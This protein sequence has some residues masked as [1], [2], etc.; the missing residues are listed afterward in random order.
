LAPNENRLDA[1]IAE[2]DQARQLAEDIR[3]RTSNATFTASPKNKMLTAT[4]NG[5]GDLRT[6][7]FRGEAYRSLA[8][9][10]LAKLIVDTVA[11]ARK[12][13]LA[14]AMEAVREL[15]PQVAMPL[16]LMDPASTLEEFIGHACSRSPASTAAQRPR[17]PAP[18]GGGR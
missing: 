5:Q 7:V 16:D 11:E 2:L 8:P 4:V 13:S 15:S 14:Q 3:Q 6:I 1:A 18:I 17:Q 10:E 9:A 12:Q